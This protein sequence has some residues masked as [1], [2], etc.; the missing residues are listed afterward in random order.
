MLILHHYSMSPFSEKIRLMCG[1]A[2]VEW[3]SV[4]TTEAPPRPHLEKLAGGYRRIPVA[5]VGADIFCDSRLIAVENAGAAGNADLNP[6]AADAA[7]RELADRY[8]GE[9]F[10]AAITSIPPSRILRKLFSELTIG[11]AFRFLK[12]RA[13]VAKNA[14]LKPMARKEAVPL[15]QAH[16]E[17]LERH[18]TDSGDF[19]AGSA[20]AH[21]DFAAYHTLWFQ[22]A[23]GGIPLPEALMQVPEWYRRVSAFGHGRVRD[24]SDDEARDAASAALPAELAIGVAGDIDA[25]TPVQVAP[26]DYALDATA[27]VLVARDAERIVIE[28]EDARLGRLGVHVPATGFA[29]ARTNGS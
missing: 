16:L 18:L 8:E 20:P 29:I 23:V 12:D 15:Y 24:G 11:G 22:H 13:G 2:G 25:G 14:R 3:L 1:Y 17:N 19:L 10:W 9:L 21:L 26:V 6:Y 7:T 4:T 27:G 5:Q 28:R